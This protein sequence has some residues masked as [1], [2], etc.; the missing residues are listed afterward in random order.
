MS[1]ADSARSGR[2][3]GSRILLAELALAVAGFA[4]ANCSRAPDERANDARKGDER[5]DESAS[6]DTA[7]DPDALDPAAGPQGAGKPG[8]GRWRI[9]PRAPTYTPEQQREIDKL[10]GLGYSGGSELAPSVS[11]VTVHVAGR[12]YEGA[13]LYTSGHAPEAVLMDMDGKVLHTWHADVHELWSP[14]ELPPRLLPFV[15]FWRRV[16]LLPNGE[17]LAIFDGHSLVKLDKDSHVL[18]K[19]RCRAHHDLE[20]LPNGDILVLTR[21]AHLVPTLDPA[22]PVLEDFV[23]LLDANGIE[24][25]RFSL[26][27]ALDA[28]PYPELASLAHARR[29]DIL[30]TNALR[31]LDGNLAARIPAFRAGNLLVSSRTLSFLAVVDPE[32]KAIVWTMRGAFKTQHDPEVLA[33]G[34]LLVFDNAGLGEASRVLELDPVSGAT[35]WE[36]RG[37]PAAPFYSRTCGTAQRLPN[38]DTLVTESDAGRAFEV[39]PAGEIVWEFW[40]PARSGA[41]REYIATLFEL[42]R[43][44]P[45]EP[46]GW[47]R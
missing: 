15:Q 33:N 5:K 17:L 23:S 36:Y 19:S 10:N 8:A 45:D 28:S 18:W 43:L 47:L 32:K 13:N 2:L 21:E 39:T 24:K 29:D 40:N 34:D 38:G 9:D 27:D 11:S 14:E 30:H 44:P 26:L 41:H 35:V 42:V 20:L 31:V 1:Q 7:L 16:R 46:L 22:K 37:T 3:K 12:A 4:L 25:R 6:D